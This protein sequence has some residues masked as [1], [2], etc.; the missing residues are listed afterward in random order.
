MSSMKI[1]VIITILSTFIFANVTQQNDKTFSNILEKISSK[2]DIEQKTELYLLAL[3]T[4][5]NISASLPFDKLKSKMLAKISQ[6]QQDKKLNDKELKELKDAYL[7][8]IKSI[9]KPT[10]YENN[11]YILIALVGVFVG[12]FI[13]YLKFGKKSSKTEL[14]GIVVEHS[15]RDKKIIKDLQDMNNKLKK[16]I[17]LLKLEI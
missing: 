15:D 2:I 10:I 6:L 4:Q 13:A 1:L 5:K 7:S 9:Q 17:N 16:E 14:Q 12:F 3:S 8:M 11:I